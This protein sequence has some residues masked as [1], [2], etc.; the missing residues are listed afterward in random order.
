MRALVLALAGAVIAL[1]QPAAAMSVQSDDPAMGL[2]LTEN[3]RAIVEIA[4]CPEGVCGRTVWIAEPN[5]ADGHPKLDV[6]NPDAGL[7][8]KALCGVALIGGFGQKGR[9]DWD[10]GW[11]YNP[12]DG[13][14]YSA[15]LTA[16]SVDELKVRGFVGL[17][18]FGKSQIWSRV[19][20]DRGGCP[21]E[22]AAAAAV[23][24]N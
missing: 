1:S 8:N 20:D 18:L 6:N 9:G 23:Q 10:G 17:P 19:T 14:R 12:K 7:R 24:A 11:I 13:E 21:Q 15:Q 2:W 22:I 16:V 3:K 4:P 5:D